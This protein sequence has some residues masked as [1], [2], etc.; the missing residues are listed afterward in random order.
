MSA[1]D[2]TFETIDGGRLALADCAGRPVLVVNTASECG[3]TPQYAGLQQL[4]ER[5]R[6]RGLVI[7][8]VPSNDFGGQEPGSAADIRAFCE[9]RFGVGFPLAAKQRVV[10]DDAH[11]FYRWIEAEAGEAAAPRWNFH[12]YLVGPA[13]ELVGAWPSRVDPLADEITAAIEA[14]LNED[15]G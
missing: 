3:F 10:G 12:K 1:H 4:W 15:Q 13:G 14:L 8:G 9:S 11:P 2:F 7:L 6:E 5:Y